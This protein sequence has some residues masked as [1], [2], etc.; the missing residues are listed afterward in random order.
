MFYDCLVVG[1]FILKLKEDDY[2]MVWWR[3]RFERNYFFWE[4][5]CKFKNLLSDNNGKGSF[6]WFCYVIGYDIYDVDYVFVWFVMM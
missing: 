4:L 3:D 1:F 2:K 6:I 5:F